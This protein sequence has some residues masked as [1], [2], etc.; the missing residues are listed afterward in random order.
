MDR[1]ACGL[2][3]RA[4]LIGI[5]SRNFGQQVGWVELEAALAGRERGVVALDLAGDEAN[6]PGE[7][8]VEHFR[9][10][11]EAGLHTIAHAGEADGARSVRQALLGLG[12][13]RIG[14]GIRA[15]DD[16]SVLDLL[17]ERSIPLEVCPTSNLQ[18]STVA[19]WSEHPLPRFLERG[20]AVTINTDDPSISGIDLA[21]EYRVAEEKL[22]LDEAALLRC[23]EN[24]LAAAFL[25]DAERDALLESAR[26]ADP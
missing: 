14:H 25:S 6:W 21:H 19:S 2:P 11:R 24:A 18:T 16:D 15:I 23:Q 7:L 12:A 1:R 5:I 8:F 4:R 10:A 3:P 26:A 13:E 22:G 20:L 9:R 17:A